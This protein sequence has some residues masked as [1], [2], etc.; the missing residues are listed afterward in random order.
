MTGDGAFMKKN[1]ELR[2]ESAESVKENRMAQATELTPDII[3]SFF[4][5]L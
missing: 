5:S 2:N 1:A 3:Q 4:L